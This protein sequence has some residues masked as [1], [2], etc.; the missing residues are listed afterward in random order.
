[1][2]RPAK[3]C[4]G[5]AAHRLHCQGTA[6]Q[7]SAVPRHSIVGVKT[8]GAGGAREREAYS[9]QAEHGGGRQN[10]APAVRGADMRISGSQGPRMEAYRHASAFASQG[11]GMVCE[12]PLDSA[13]AILSMATAEAPDPLAGSATARHSKARRRSAAA[14]ARGAPAKLWRAA[15]CVA[16]A[17]LLTGSRRGSM[18]TGILPRRRGGTA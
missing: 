6:G 1:M 7:R 18:A 4:T 9:A 15:H 10:E 14:W 11:T 3:S 2:R 12:S 8:Q 16:P 13:Q 17:L 5:A